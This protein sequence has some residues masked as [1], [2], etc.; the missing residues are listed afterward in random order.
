MTG[1]TARLRLRPLAESDADAV[2]SLTSDAEVARF[3]S[4]SRQRERGE[5]CLLYTSRCV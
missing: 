1:E 4:F 5:A 2:F 3:M